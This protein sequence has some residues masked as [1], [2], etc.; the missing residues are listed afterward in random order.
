MKK[1][2]EK[3]PE[4]SAY[5]WEHVE[6]LRKTLIRILIT[7]FIGTVFSFIFYQQIFSFLTYPLKYAAISNVGFSDQ[8]VILGPAEGIMAVFKICF[9]TGI[10]GSSPVW[11]YF[12]LLFFAPALRSNERKLIFPFLFFSLLFFAMGFFF[13]FYVTI[14]AANKYLNAFNQG[15]GVNLWTLNNYLD[16][17]LIL[18][19]ANSLAFEAS[20]ILLF[21][22]HLG[23]LSAKSLK[24][25]R[26]HA[27]VLIFILSAIITP[28]DI[29]SQIMLSAPLIILYELAIGYAKLR[30]SLTIAVD[31]K[32]EN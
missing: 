29:V 18:L 8:L 15:I 9:W 5:F 6:D 24:A 16:F 2:M 23:V 27:I 19:L 7:V 31:I 30:N 25:K 10:V 22:I 21:L 11:I 1:M 12:L 4:T 32:S 28:P 13:A 26:K 3:N 17:T 20:I 14:P